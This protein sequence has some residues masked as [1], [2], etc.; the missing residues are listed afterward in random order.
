MPRPVA[1]SAALFLTLARW[2]AAS[3]VD[4]DIGAPANCL[5]VNYL[6]DDEYQ[7]HERYEGGA[8]VYTT[9][10]VVGGGRRKFECKFK[11]GCVWDDANQRCK[12]GVCVGLQDPTCS[13][14]EWCMMSDRGECV[15]KQCSKWKD[16]AECDADADC[17]W[18]EGTWA[19]GG[20]CTDP[21][22]VSCPPVDLTLYVDGSGSMF[23]KFT[24]ADQAEQAGWFATMLQLKQL[25]HHLPMSGDDHTAAK[26][27]AGGTAGFRVD[28]IQ[29]SAEPDPNEPRNPSFTRSDESDCPASEFLCTGGYMSGNADELLGELDYMNDKHYIG[30]QTFL[31]PALEDTANKIEVA[32][33][34][35]RKQVGIIMT[36]GVF[37]DLSK[38]NVVNYPDA[39][40]ILQR[41]KNDLQMTLHA[42]VIYPGPHDDAKVATQMEQNRHVVSE[43]PEEYMHTHSLGELTE[44]LFSGLCTD[45][46]PSPTDECKA[47]QEGNATC[48]GAFP[49]QLC[50]DPDFHSKGNYVCKCDESLG[51]T[52]QKNVAVADCDFDQCVQGGALRTVCEEAQV[53]GRPQTCVEPDQ[54]IDGDAYCECPLPAAGE[55]VGARAV[56][57]HDEC[58]DTTMPAAGICA[59][60]SQ[61]CNDPTPRGELVADD[62]QCVCE[63]P[64]SGVGE[65]TPALN[66]ILDECATLR[67]V[68]QA[69]MA[70]GQPQT[71]T[72]PSPTVDGDAYC[73]CP[74]PAQAKTMRG[75][76]VPTCEANECDDDAVRSTCANA[77][78][79]CVDSNPDV[80]MDWH[81]ACL[82]P[83]VAIPPMSVGQR[84]PAVCEM[85]DVAK[86]CNG[87]AVS[88]LRDD[89]TD[90]CTCTCLPGYVGATCDSCEAGY[91]ANAVT[92]DCEACSV[93]THCANHADSV[94][95]DPSNTKCICTCK[96]NYAGNS[97][98]SCAA[99]Y[100][101]YP[102]CEKCEIDRHCG[103]NAIAVKE[104]GRATCECTCKPEF[105]GPT[106][107]ECAAGFAPVGICD[108][109]AEG[110]IG[111][112]SC[113]QCTTETHCN[114]NAADVTSNPDRTECVCSCN[115]GF[116][117]PTCSNCGPGF[118]PPDCV[119]CA[120]GYVLPGCRECTVED[121]CN[122]RATAVTDEGRL[123]C[124]CT[125][126]AGWA[127]K[128]CDQC[129]DGYEAPLCDRCVAGYVGPPCVECTVDD[130]CNGNADF[131]TDNGGRSGCK[132]TCK[133]GF[134]GASCDTCDEGYGPPGVCNTCDR[135]YVNVGGLCTKCTVEEHCGGNADSVKDDG[136]NQKCVCT[137]RMGFAGPSCGECAVGFAPPGLCNS[138]ATGYVTYP[139]CEECTI[140]QHCSGKAASVTSDS[141][142]EC[143]CTCNEGFTGDS[144]DECAAGY[145]GFP[146]CAQ[147][148]VDDHCNGNAVSASQDGGR[149]AC[150]C[151]CKPGFEGP[152]CSGCAAGFIN[153][154]TCLQCN[155]RTHCSGNAVSVTDNGR[156]ECVCDCAAGFADA[157]S[158]CD[159]CAAGYLDYPSCRLV[160]CSNE[161]TCNNNAVNAVIV[162]LKCECECKLGFDGASCDRCAAGAT[163]YPSCTACSLAADC[164]GNAAAVNTNA[165]G[166]ACECT[167]LEGFSGSKCD[168]CAEGY[169]DYPN[170]RQ[171]SSETHCNGNA[172]SSTDDGSRGQCLCNCADGFE[173]G[174]CDRCGSGFIGFPDCVKCSLP[175]DCNSHAYSVTSDAT[176][177]TCVCD[178][179]VG[180]DD[181]NCD[182]CAAGYITYP[183][184]YE[185]TNHFHCSANARS[186]TS[187]PGN[188]KCVCDCK[189]GYEGDM[190]NVCAMGY[191]GYP[192]CTP[193]TC[194]VTEPC[195]GNAVSAVL[196]QTTCEC[197]CRAGYEGETCDQCAPGHVGYPNC[198]AC[199]V[200]NHC[201]ANAISATD[202]GYRAKCTCECMPGFD[203]DKCDRCAPGHVDFPSCKQC[204]IA[205]HCK[206]N[207]VDV[208][209]DGIGCVCECKENFEGITCGHCNAGYVGYPECYECSNE[210]HCNGNA[211]T[212]S[213]DGTRSGCECTCREGYI[214][215][216]CDACAAGYVGYPNCLECSADGYC[217]GNA[218]RARLDD[219][220]PEGCSCVCKESYQGANCGACAAKSFGYPECGDC[221]I[222][223][224][225]NSNADS[226]TSD[227]DGTTCE[228][229][230][231]AG[232]TGLECDTCAEAYIGYPSCSEC[233]NDLHCSGNARGV[234]S[235]ENRTSCVC[236]CVDRFAG[237]ECDV[238]APGHI[239]YPT[240]F[241]CT[242]AT[243]C[244]GLAVNVTADEYREACVCTCR[245]G[246]AGESCDKCAPGWIGY[247]KCTKCSVEE[248]CDKH[249]LS[250]TDDGTGEKCVCS[251]TPGYGG[252]SCEG[253]A[254]GVEGDNCDVCKLGYV[255][256]P[257]CDKC[258]NSHCN[259]NAFSVHSD[260]VTDTCTCRCNVGFAGDACER[261]AAG[262]VSYPNCTECTSA[263][264]CNGNAVNATDN[265]TLQVCFC[266]CKSNF[267]GHACETCAADHINYPTCEKCSSEAHCNGNAV[268]AS[269]NGT[270]DGC[271][272]DCKAG[273]T[274][275]FCDACA[276]GYVGYPDCVI[277]G[278]DTACYGNAISAVVDSTRDKCVCTCSVGYNG[279]R[280]SSCAAGYEGPQ[281]VKSPETPGPPTPSPAPRGT[282]A[283]CISESGLRCGENSCAITNEK[284]SEIQK[285]V[286]QSAGLPDT[287][288]NRA[289]VGV[290]DTCMIDVE[291]KCRRGTCAVTVTLPGEHRGEMDE[292][293][294]KLRAGRC[295]SLQRVGF[296]DPVATRLGAGEQEDNDDD[297]G[298][299][300]W[301]I[302]LLVGL[303]LLLLCVAWFC[304]QKKGAANDRDEETYTDDVA[305][306]PNTEMY[307]LPEDETPLHP[308]AYAAPMPMATVP[309]S[310]SYPG[311]HSRNLSAPPLQQP[312]SPG[313]MSSPRA[314]LY[315][316][317]TGTGS[318]VSASRASISASPGGKP[319]SSA[320]LA[321]QLGQ[322]TTPLPRTGSSMQTIPI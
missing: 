104:I 173:G 259:G 156:Q 149:D 303:C 5:S 300:W 118:A 202:D 271:Q 253:C 83:M 286:A 162:G 110:F 201:G 181:L 106:C 198:E 227:Q 180:F 69:A 2:A 97:C 17:G 29:F 224:Y 282:W 144:C 215:D 57:V 55:Q 175:V 112:P 238:C 9:V 210:L 292:C 11:D 95:T 235:D 230:C 96:D 309:P 16:K 302:A 52:G 241:E 120:A 129:E 76:A 123:T 36:D 54:T 261:C 8:A 296:V 141:R 93:A 192:H 186:V 107:S 74:A 91:V 23:S 305:P 160:E 132:C 308:M 169:V 100:I 58:A 232:F 25:V 312:Q 245:E 85:C 248:H 84:A 145:V 4:P 220:M 172:W 59:G 161:R 18:A 179:K 264:A 126:V 166:T 249:A 77:G 40:A 63:P 98:E 20:V 221:T 46:I 121:D 34:A 81:C 45:F 263:S 275:D 182:R 21:A 219:S 13:D 177:N 299:P 293:V 207:G 19:A 188:N 152:T 42:I 159:R 288:E 72:D 222:E 15:P 236:S 99:G 184:C 79:Q 250:V 298:L 257:A 164:S 101:T 254:E 6:P 94:T 294:G 1:P 291:R 10:Q 150:T 218:L 212:A 137:C 82:A 194:S 119:D 33:A 316:S 127:G 283:L 165:R 247:P 195:N 311:D 47:G 41:L 217:Q 229:T 183:Q 7:K 48:G 205:F 196:I 223:E 321:P 280:C 204:S 105:S 189:T 61:E 67:P 318:F 147:C 274:G 133:R 267:D 277:C 306:A 27:G 176:G 130:H 111:Y 170:C 44:A 117:P 89:A 199:D 168:E 279:T 209:S 35:G 86:H 64:K 139:R 206:G 260:E 62:W 171:C 322:R 213:E 135:N 136:L 211:V 60:S 304:M 138:C 214:G 22:F 108:Q 49:A 56:C 140:Q 278:V 310:P 131:V 66:C 255:N 151:T 178:C 273:Y 109:C 191:D 258:D 242:A 90:T 190:C 114:D 143:S 208:W 87:K 252:E 297:G 237:A 266:N 65:Q 174:R 155:A 287:E 225:C 315:Q 276:A 246:F 124:E 128:S 157:Q 153:Y 228:C 307:P 281:C 163:G 269:M 116:D 142:G 43:P 30:S 285:H 113:T 134:T 146:N 92:G 262:Y 51:Y 32:R 103:G 240:C 88:S 226:I 37:T 234:T 244:N 320:F 200:M 78:Q 251:C 290:D 295:P 203:G 71:C 122:G 38:D 216:Q 3:A 68:C 185:C 231:S 31:W 268:A 256:H 148:S 39:D 80:L 193:V 319:R 197:S 265:D 270:G 154:P 70:F 102:T 28:V 289:K 14:N 233:T 125:C 24:P 75:A 313:R 115:A 167:C 243:H 158:G 53:Y 284:A 239:S 12:D 272:C 301:L 187:D 314:S 317:P 26:T 50:D 73:Q